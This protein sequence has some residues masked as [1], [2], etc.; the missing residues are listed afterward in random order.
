MKAEM[1]RDITNNT[2]ARDQDTCV[3]KTFMSRLW[4]GIMKKWRARGHPHIK[5]ISPRLARD[6]GLSSAEVAQHQH[7]WPSEGTDHLNR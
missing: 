5:D 1:M 6:A 2:P 3:K 4:I 7:I